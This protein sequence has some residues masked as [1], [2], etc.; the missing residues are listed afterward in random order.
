MIYQDYLINNLYISLLKEEIDGISIEKPI[1][2]YYS[3][4]FE[5][6]TYFPESS[7]NIS[8]GFGFFNETLKNEFNEFLIKNYNEDQL[9]KMLDNWINNDKYEIDKDLFNLDGTRGIIKYLIDSDKKPIAFLENGIPKGYEFEL[10]YKFAKE[11]GYKIKYGSHY[12]IEGTFINDFDLYFGCLNIY[13]DYDAQ[14]GKIMFSNPI[15]KT[16]IVLAVKTKNK[17]DHLTIQVLDK[18]YNY[19]SNNNM[20]ILAQVLYQVR[21]TS[22]IF[23]KEYNDIIL[24]N[25][26]VSD[27]DYNINGTITGVNFLN[28]SDLIK[29]TYSNIKPDNFLNADVI[30]K[31]DSP[32]NI[33]N[34]ANS[35]KT[36]FLVPGAEHTHAIDEDPI[37]YWDKV[38]QFININIK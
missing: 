35:T 20:Q 34:E 38:D 1:A 15:Y 24:I 14:L 16:N 28:T 30:F 13:N 2:E 7:E 9:N 31:D 21:N 17:K 26:S 11:Y 25:C 29:I 8:Y 18:D 4:H 37:G 36:L 23:P 22:C 3:K 33:Y 10:L 6:L 32:E 5:K 19:K 12:H 27:F